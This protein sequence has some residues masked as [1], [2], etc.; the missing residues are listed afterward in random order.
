MCDLIIDVFAQVP[1][2]I[3]CPFR[4]KKRRKKGVKKPQNTFVLGIEP[5]FAENH[6]PFGLENPQ[7]KIATPKSIIKKKRGK[8]LFKTQ[9]E[10]ESPRKRPQ[11]PPLPTH[12]HNE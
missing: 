4:K 8:K 7:M 3:S 1:I 6:P 2:R 11:N 12:H 9:T 10:T 5:K